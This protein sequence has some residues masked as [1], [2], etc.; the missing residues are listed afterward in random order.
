VKS[1]EVASN[2]QTHTL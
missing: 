2:K 1:G